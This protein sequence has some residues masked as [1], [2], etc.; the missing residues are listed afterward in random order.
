M[1]NKRIELAAAAAIVM[2]VLGGVTFW[3]GQTFV[4]ILDK[5]KY[6]VALPVDMFTPKIPE[7]FVEADNEKIRA[8]AEREEK[9]RFVYANVLAGLKEEIATVLN[10][11]K[12]AVYWER[13]T[14]QIAC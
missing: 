9:E 5:F 1:H 3:P 4:L 14:K 8:A 12:T 7:D 13:S 10:E 11:F 6:Y 2:V